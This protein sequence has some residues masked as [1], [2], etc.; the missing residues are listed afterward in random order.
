[1]EKILFVADGCPTCE[2]VKALNLAEVDVLDPLADRDAAVLA[3]LYDV[4]VFPTYLE[5]E[6]DVVL[7]SVEGDEVQKFLEKA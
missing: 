1:M 6:D 5:L 4:F 2:A 7:N 3:A